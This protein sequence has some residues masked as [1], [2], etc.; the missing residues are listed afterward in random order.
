MVAKNLQV[1]VVRFMLPTQS[2]A[3]ERPQYW[4]GS[5]RRRAAGGGQQL[6]QQP[7]LQRVGATRGGEEGEGMRPNGSSAVEASEIDAD[8]MGC[9]EMRESSEAGGCRLLRLRR[10]G[11]RFV[12]RFPGSVSTQAEEGHS[13]RD[14]EEWSVQCFSGL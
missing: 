14:M 11:M 2:Q 10:T 13:P 3:R 9:R 7:C 1:S 5:G 4:N 12:A 8:T 6:V